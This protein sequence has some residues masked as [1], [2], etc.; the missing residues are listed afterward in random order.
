[1]AELPKRWQILP[2]YSRYRLGPLDIHHGDA[3]KGAGGRHVA[4]RMLE[5][6]KRS[7]LFGHF[8]REQMYP[9]PDGDGVVRAGYASGHLCDEHEAGKYC[10][11]NRWTKGYRTVDMDPTLGLFE[12]RGHSIHSGRVRADGITY[13][14]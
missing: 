8:H 2:Q 11:I 10:P 7:S 4:C 13:G 6:L 5:D 1:M 9:E 14:G 3:K 12:V